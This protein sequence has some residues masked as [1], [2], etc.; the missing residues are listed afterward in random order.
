MPIATNTSNPEGDPV[1]IVYS[2][3]Q[4]DIELA[5]QEYADIANEA[6]KSG[7]DIGWFLDSQHELQRM[8][9]MENRG[10]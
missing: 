7:M 9:M 4:D 1:N 2:V 10:E 5:Y 8:Y 6:D 3:E